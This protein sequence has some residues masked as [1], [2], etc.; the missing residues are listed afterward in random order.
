[1]RPPPVRVRCYAA[2]ASH[3]ARR[4]LCH[5]YKNTHDTKEHLALVIDPYQND[6]GSTQMGA[7]GRPV[8]ESDPVYQQHALRSRSLDEVWGS[9]ET[10]M[11]RIVRGAYVGDLD[12]AFRWR[13]DVGS[14]CAACTLAHAFRAGRCAV[15]AGAHS[16]RV[17]SGETI[18]SQRCDCGEQLDEA[19]RLI[20]RRTTRPR[21]QRSG[22]ISHRVSSV[23][24]SLSTS[25]R[26]TWDWAVG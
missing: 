1:M 21:P 25:P 10:D 3:A 17:L 14:S 8:K 4:D 9:A 2:H 20:S 7:D 16:L 24:A 23:A 5:L 19:I 22:R 13:R 12:R 18:G 11:E 15:P 26:G 6:E